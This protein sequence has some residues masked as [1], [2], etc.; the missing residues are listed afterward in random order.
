[1]VAAR[2]LLYNISILRRIAVEAHEAELL[3]YE[4]LGLDSHNDA[5]P[6]CRKHKGKSIGTLNAERA[7][8]SLALKF[9]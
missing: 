8:G 2:V 4:A 7:I 5:N 1:M 6:H 9:Q 3:A